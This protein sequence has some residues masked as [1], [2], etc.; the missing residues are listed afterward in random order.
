MIRDLDTRLA[1]WTKAEQIR[2]LL[3]EAK[4]AATNKGRDTSPESAMDRWLKWAAEY[5]DGIAASAIRAVDE[6]E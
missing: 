3:E 5:A 6:S 1:S 4:R 2:S